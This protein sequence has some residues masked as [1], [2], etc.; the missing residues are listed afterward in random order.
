[1]FNTS[2]THC[3]AVVIRSRMHRSHDQWVVDSV[4]RPAVSNIVPIRKLFIRRVEGDWFTLKPPY[5]PT[6]QI[7]VVSVTSS[8]VYY[9]SSDHVLKSRDSIPEPP[10]IAHSVALMRR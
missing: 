9:S 2:S 7:Q 5:V 6:P 8:V 3:D 10:T 1:M 4:F